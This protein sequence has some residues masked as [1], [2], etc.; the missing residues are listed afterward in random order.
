MKVLMDTSTIV[1][2]MLPTHPD[3]S[4]A[5]PWL[6]QANARA[7]ELFVSLHSIAELYAVLTRLPIKPA[8]TPVQADGL[9]KGNLFSCAKSVSLSE[10][11]YLSIVSDLAKRG[12]SGGITYDAVIARAAEL[13]KV[14]LLVTFNI[15]HFQRVW[16]AGAARVI[17]AH[18]PPP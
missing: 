6:M 16:P 3:N 8:V 10:F 12:L 9:I 2:A 7:F 17:S 5:E 1:A 4:I 13:A 15:S 18:T 14:D 11:D